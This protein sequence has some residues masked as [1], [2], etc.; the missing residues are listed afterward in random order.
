MLTIQ[1]SDSVFLDDGQR[2]HHEARYR[3]VTGSGPQDG[4]KINTCG[5]SESRGDQCDL[6]R[7]DA[8]FIIVSANTRFDGGQIFPK[9][10]VRRDTVITSTP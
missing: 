2:E 10:E 9:R 4:P 8:I 7:C 5:A 6:I 3:V 1:S